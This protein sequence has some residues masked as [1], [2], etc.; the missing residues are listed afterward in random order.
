[1]NLIKELMDKIRALNQLQFLFLDKNMPLAESNDIKT[2]TAYLNYCVDK[3]VS[4]AFLA[5]SYDLIVK[6]MFKEQVYFQRHKRYRHS[7]YSDVANSVYQNK[8]YMTKY[9]Y[10][11]ALTAFL[12]PNH[13][14]IH[15]FFLKEIVKNRTGQYLEIGPGHGLYFMQSMINGR[16]SSYKGVDI[17]PTSVEMT[18]D[19][20]Q[21]KHFGDFQ[22]YTIECSDFLTS[23]VSGKYDFI[24]MSEVLEHVE[25]PDIFLEKIKILL[26]KNGAAFITTCINSPAIDHIFLY[27]TVEM[28][29]T[30]VEKA[31]L[32]VVTKLIV[33]YANLTLEESMNKL[34]P[35]NVAMSLELK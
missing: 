22:D 6:D 3:G 29:V 32:K 33:P 12:W 34:L 20:L 27:D 9:M 17:S 2:F 25:N 14:A 35:V 15:H 5:E 18:K 24:V 4:I 19:I 10:G 28:L 30:Q 21:S 31:G 26:N 1:M 23:S 13:R 7:N 16:F 8:E 11:L